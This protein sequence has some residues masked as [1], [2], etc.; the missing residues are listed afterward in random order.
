M[1]KAIY[2]EI[3]DEIGTQTLARFGLNIFSL[4]TYAGYEA[5]IAMTNEA[6]YTHNANKNK[7]KPTQNNP[8]EYS[9][10]RGDIFDAL[11]SSTLNLKSALDGSGE[12]LYSTDRLYEI[13]E[14][15]KINE[16]IKKGE[17]PKVLPKFYE[18]I[19][20]N[21]A[22]EVKNM[23]FNSKELQNLAT[24][25]N[26]KS[27]KL[28]NHESTDS[29]TFDKNGKIIK[30][31]QLKTTK[32]PESQFLQT[33]NGIDATKENDKNNAFMVNE[34]KSDIS[35]ITSQDGS[36]IY[37]KHKDGS[38][39]Y[40]YIENNDNITVPYDDYV[41]CKEELEKIINDTSKPQEKR[42]RA[43]QALEKLN[44]N[45]LLNRT[46]LENP[47]TTAATVQS[48]VAASHIAQAGLSDA[49]VVCLST[50]ANGAIYEIKDAFIG[51]SE[52]SLI[53]RLERLIKKSLEPFA[54]T[55]KRGAGFGAIDILI[56]SL[57]QILTQIGKRIAKLWDSVR[58]SA[59]SIYNA[60]CDYVS[61]KIKTFGEMVSVIVKSLFSAA[62]V[63]GSALL[64]T[65][66]DAYLAP[67][68]T[69]TISSILSPAITIVLCSIAVVMGAKFIDKAL[70]CFFGVY[71]QLQKSRQK[72]AEISALAD[73]VLPELVKD[74]DKIEELMKTK[75]KQI[76]A[77]LESSFET[78]QKAFS[79]DDGELLLQSLI[80]INDIYGKKLK[81][82]DKEEFWNAALSGDIIK[83]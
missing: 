25:G 40:K 72:A 1:S 22:D 56:K 31:E 39:I 17:K 57:A 77:S 6:V 66:L 47:R 29:V 24:S 30:K 33:P 27:K 49:T 13:Q 28:K 81:Y 15:Q 70:S 16:Q 69:P 52:I 78:L 20:T 5:S 61:G 55:F 34:D 43:K 82:T 65:Q 10:Y 48:V 44:K 54:Q 36:K 62:M 41:F 50:L 53:K 74:N 71:A 63:F 38:D 7:I 9:S 60:I 12:R 75:F 18:F 59:K 3:I 32:N 68:L 23:D 45:N 64:E 80:S 73:E 35:Y 46:M 26:Y 79:R 14:T 67:I 8:D 83:I 4:N 42:L 19:M 58:T 11:H 37:I 2:E 51:G 21:Y 76:S